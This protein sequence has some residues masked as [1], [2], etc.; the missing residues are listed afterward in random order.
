VEGEE[1]M[2]TIRTLMDNLRRNTPARFAGQAVLYKKDYLEGT[3]LDM[4]G[5]RERKDIDLPSS[6]VIQLLLKDQTLVSA[7]PSGTEPKIKFYASC[8]SAP[9]L[10]LSDAKQEVDRKIA[11]VREEFESLTKGVAG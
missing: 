8:R 5:G 4:K 2:N 3:T 9:G 6:N 7:R 1:G 10:E 11:H